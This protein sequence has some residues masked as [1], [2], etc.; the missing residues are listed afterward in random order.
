MILKYQGTN[1]LPQIS[2]NYCVHDMYAEGRSDTLVVRFNDPKSLWHRWAPAAGDTIELED[3]AAR[4]GR[5]YVSRIQTENGLYTL[6]AMS[7]P[8]SGETI[9]SK[10]WEAV[11]FLQI[12]REIAD[13]HDLTFQTYGCTDQVYSF[14]SQS[15]QTDFE[16][17]WER[18]LLEGCQMLIYDGRLLIYNERHIESQ[19]AAATVAVGVDGVFAY[20][21]DSARSYGASEVSGGVY[22]GYYQAPGSKTS[23]VLRPRREI[24][25][26]S[27]AEATRYARGLLR[28]VNKAAIRG[29]YR[30]ALSPGFAAASLINLKTQKAG[31]WNGK[32]FVSH[33]RHDY[34][35]NETTIFWRKPLEE[36]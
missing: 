29:S 20:T 5:M 21:D 36:Y 12:G 16:F 14:L 27:N 23:R 26:T 10:S 17:L 25:V 9:S 1:I 11:R 28:S 33:V 2:L 22:R 30:Q 18:C 32:V 7:M 31:A 24:P 13:R 6:R 34:V 15:H 3:G 19:Q 4:T 35:R 8:L